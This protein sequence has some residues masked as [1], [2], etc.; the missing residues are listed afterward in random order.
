MNNRVGPPVRGDDCY[1]REAFVQLL[2]DKLTV[3]HVL[4]AAPVWQDERIRL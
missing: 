3:G 4:L 1:G 2:W